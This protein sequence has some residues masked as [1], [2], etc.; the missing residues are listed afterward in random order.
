ME[1]PGLRPPTQAY[2]SSLVAPTRAPLPSEGSSSGVPRPTA[3]GRKPRLFDPQS[4]DGTASPESY[5]A[6]LGSEL[7]GLDDSLAA[8][9]RALRLRQTA[10]RVTILAALQTLLA[11]AVFSAQAF[12]DNPSHV[13]MLVA[14]IA[15]FSGA[16]GLYGGQRRHAWALQAFFMTQIWVLACVVAEWLRSQQAA[17]REAIFC[18][19]R[20]EAT[21]SHHTSSCG[22]GGGF[23]ACASLPMVLAD[24]L[25]EQL[26]DSHELADEKALLHFAWLMHKKTLVGVQR[27]EE[28]LHAKF[29]ELVQLGFLKP[30]APLSS[31]AAPACTGD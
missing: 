4:G 29:D 28:R 31:R 9:S 2:L 20:A 12:D 14:V 1:G 16:L 22:G 13:P 17:A 10:S 3:A 18:K 15:G 5:F 11:A 27:F 19:E 21:G 26:Q 24:L 30:R 8:G 7:R 25:S 23:A 6:P